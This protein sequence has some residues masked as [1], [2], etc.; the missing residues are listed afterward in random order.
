MTLRE[1]KSCGFIIYPSDDLSYG[2]PNCE[3]RHIGK[4]NGI[5][6]EN[7]RKSQLTDSKKVKVCQ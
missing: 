5:I 1:C 6:G 2:C 4:Y 3:S 7:I